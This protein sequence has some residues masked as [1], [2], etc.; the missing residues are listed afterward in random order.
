MRRILERIKEFRDRRAENPSLIRPCFFGMIENVIKKYP[1]VKI[2]A[3]T[4]ARG[5]SNNR[6]V[7]VLCLDCGKT[8]SAPTLRMDVFDRVGGG[9]G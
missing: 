6:Q 1:H 7:G 8:Y 5:H 9:D 4:F 2:V 3:T